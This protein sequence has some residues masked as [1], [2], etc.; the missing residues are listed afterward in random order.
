MTAAH[1]WG[2]VVSETKYNGTTQ[3]VQKVNNFT[4]FSGNN[5]L[6]SNVQLK[7]KSGPT[8]TRA[9]F[10]QY[11]VM[12]NI[13]EMQ[14]TNDLKQS[15]IWDYRNTQPIAEV[16]GAGQ[17]DVAYTSFEGDATG[18]WSGIS[19]P[20]FVVNGS[21]TGKRAY[22]KTSFN[23][24]KTGLSTS[25]SYLVSYWSKNGAYSVNGA[26]ATSLRTIND[27]SLYQ[28]TVVNPSGGTVTVSGT[29]TIDELRLY[30][31]AAIMKTFTYEPLIGVS[32]ACD[33]NNHILYYSYDGF[34]RLSLIKDE[35]GKIL[36][37]YCYNYNNQS[38][39]CS[40]FGNTAQ[41]SVFIRNSCGADYNGSQITYTVP[42]N[43]YLA[44]T[45]A[46]ANILALNDMT[47]N[48]QAYANVYAGCTPQM[49]TITGSD[50]KN[51]QYTVTFTGV[52]P[53]PPNVY[54]FIIHPGDNNLTLG[55]I[56]KGHYNVQFQPGGSPPSATFAVGSNMI[57]PIPGGSLFNNL[58]LV[59]NTLVR[60]F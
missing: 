21:V 42:V 43:T 8:E 59:T 2:K 50:S 13:L 20:G 4:S 14:K 53:T 35:T 37:Q 58:Y 46:E 29:G 1:I 9:S 18:G 31:S 40:L 33:A 54:S 34:S 15:F 30:P 57:G 36:K 52:S 26:P 32:S 27:W 47:A 3:L 45:Q 44:S 10:N 23:I 48:G 41:S 60:A 55:Q 22:T 39:S 49:I 28:H 12:G 16:T 24:S 11:D 25:T 7:V 5:Y 38:S 51:I 56:P 19:G 6:P 17:S